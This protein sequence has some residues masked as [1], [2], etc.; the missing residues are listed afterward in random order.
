MNTVKLSIEFSKRELLTKYK[1]SVFGVAWLVGSPILLLLLYSA[2]F[3]FVFKAKWDIDGQEYNFTQALFCGLAPY[4]FFTE[5]IGKSPD[6][7]KNNSNLI[8]KVVFDRLSVPLS[9]TF[10]ALFIFAINITLVLIFKIIETG[11]VNPVWL[12][13]YL[14]LIPVFFMGLTIATIFSSIGAY[15]RDLSSIANF[16]NPVLMFI[17]PVF[18]NID[19]INPLFAVL[20]TFNPLTPII[21]NIR[22]VVLQNYFDVSS[23]VI[24][25]ICSA[26]AS[27]VG[28]FIYRTLEEDFSDL[29]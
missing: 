25:T 6:L 3:Q 1:G 19:K 23:F 11:G 9:S 16:I 24:I 29:I 10:S 8:K 17:S 18:F 7:V 13:T 28:I 2:V 21:L 15:V 20:I 27:L 14:Y 4:F 22:S 26:L 12:M 5:M